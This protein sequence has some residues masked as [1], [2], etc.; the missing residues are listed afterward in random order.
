MKAGAHRLNDGGEWRG[1]IRR[2]VR[3]VGETQNGGNEHKDAAW[4]T[5]MSANGTVTAQGSA[6]GISALGGSALGISALGGSSRFGVSAERL[7]LGTY[8]Y[9][10]AY[11]DCGRTLT[12]LR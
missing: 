5:Y 1:C 2:V 11:A 6:R 3:P 10:S 7:L 9:A 4:S 12:R 8:V